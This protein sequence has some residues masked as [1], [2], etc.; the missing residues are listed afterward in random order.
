MRILLLD[1][2]NIS[3][4]L[5]QVLTH[6]GHDIFATN[7]HY[8]TSRW[9][10]T[11]GFLPN[12]SNVLDKKWDLVVS[13]N[14]Y[15]NTCGIVEEFR[16]RGIPTV[17]SGV[18][19]FQMEE[20]NVGRKIFSESG[21]KCP[22]WMVFESSADAIRYLESGEMKSVV[23][24]F[25]TTNRPMRTAVFNDTNDA[26]RFLRDAKDGR[27]VLEERV[28]GVEVAFSAYYD[29]E[30][31]VPTV[32]NFEHKHMFN[33]NM[34]I[35]VPE[36]GTVAVYS[37]TPSV[38]ELMDSLL[39]SKEASRYLENYRGLIDVNC[40]VDEFGLVYALEFTCRFGVP[41]TDIMT[42]LLKWSGGAYGEFLLSVANGK[43]DETLLV[44]T[45]EYAVG[46]NLVVCGYGYHELFPNLCQL[47][48]EIRGYDKLNCHHTFGD[49]TARDSKLFVAH[50]WVMCVVGNGN[51]IDEARFNMLS[52]AE[53]VSFQDKVYRTDIGERV[54]DELPFLQRVGLI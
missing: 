49:V 23:V 43:M 38:K 18:V 44:H 10:S 37:P 29:G 5:A 32:T 20:K 11:L 3:D 14:T 46:A 6:E 47:G 48:S 52:G 8:G 16:A 34:G 53:K 21:F 54:K 28:C 15:T 22:K 13:C 31:F 40:I 12:Y 41:I 1:H 4:A 26:I 30:R 36:M 19:G 50:P 24:K 2:G 27:V 51:T 7:D 42:S 33:G 17:G 45:K 35:L 25:S 9:G 39:Q